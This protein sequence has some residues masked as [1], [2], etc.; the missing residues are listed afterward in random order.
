MCEPSSPK[1]VG[2][3]TSSGYKRKH[4]YHL[5]K[6]APRSAVCPSLSPPNSPSFWCM[7]VCIICLSFAPSLFFFVLILFSFL[8]KQLPLYNSL[9]VGSILPCF[10]YFLFIPLGSLITCSPFFL[11]LLSL[12]SKTWPD[13]PISHEELEEDGQGALFGWYVLLGFNGGSEYLF[14]DATFDYPESG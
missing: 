1:A 11:C 8:L 9:F 12:G 4:C 13:P 3:V 14:R 7:K 5:Q 6:G 2:H 10:R